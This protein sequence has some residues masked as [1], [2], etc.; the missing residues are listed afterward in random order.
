M[1]QFIFGRPST[2]KT[3]TVIEKIKEA[4]TEK[5][6]AVLIVPEQF[7]FE[8]EKA[9]LKEIGDSAALNVS[10]LSFSRLYDEVGRFSGL[11]AGTVLSDS[12]KIIMMKRAL[13][14]SKPFLSSNRYVGSSGYAKA[15]LDTVGELKINA[16]TPSDLR[17]A[18]FSISSEAL[19]Q[20][21]NDTATIYE[22]YD[23][24]VGE[25]FLDPADRL[26]KLYDMLG[27][28]EY[29]K[30]KTVLFDTFKGF[31]G[32]QYKIIDRVLSQA[33][34][35]YI[36]FTNDPDSK[37]DFNVFSNIRKTVARIERLA[38]NHS[39]KINKP[40][41]LKTKHY[42]SKSLDVLEQVVSGDNAVFA[43]RDGGVT[44]CCAENR[45]DEADFAASTIR[46]LVRDKG[47]RYRDFIIISR[48]AADYEQAVEYACIE[49]DVSCFIDKRMPLSSF[50]AAVAAQNAVKA[51]LSFST[52]S[53]L[54]FNKTGL[55]AL[56][57]EEISI[58]EN[59]VFL[60]KI[61]GEMWN[62][63]W[64]MDVRGFVTEPPEEKHL[65][66]LDE[67]NA[68]REKAIRPILSFKDSFKGTPQNLASAIIKLFEECNVSEKLKQMCVKL[69]SS[70]DEISPDILK[71]SYDMYINLLESTVRCLPET[72]V[73]KEDFVAS[74]ETAVSLS[75][76][77]VI[78]QTLDEVT[79]GSADRIRPSRPKIAFILGAN[80]GV[81]PRVNNKSGVFTS[82]ERRVLSEYGV[83]IGNDLIADAVD[84][85]FLVYTNL[86]CPSDKLYI[87]YSKTALNGEQYEKSAFLNR[88]SELIECEK[89]TY[90]ESS[91]C[92]ANL[93][94]TA[95]AAYT[96][97]CRSIN[98]SLEAAQTIKKALE[99]CGLEE[100]AQGLEN[101]VKRE[102]SISEETAQMLYGEDLYMSA[103]RIDTFSRCPFSYFC[104]YGLKAEKLR[105]AEFNVLQRGTIVHYV[106]ERLINNNAGALKTLSKTE[107][108]ELVDT[109]IEEYLDS[110][111]GYRSIETVYSRFIASKISKLLK[112][113]VSHM[114]EEFSQSCFEPYGCEVKIG[115]EGEIPALKIPFDKGNIVISG[116][117]DRLDKYNGYIR[118]VDYKTG[119]REFKISDVLYG[120]NLQ[121]LIYLYAAVKGSKEDEKAAGIL[122]MQPSREEK[123]KNTAMNGL[124]IKDLSVVTAME[125]ENRGEFVPRLSV[126]KD[127]SFSKTNNSFIDGEDFNEIFTYIDKKLCGIGNKIASGNIDIDPVDGYKSP[128]CKYCDFASVCGKEDITPKAAAVLKTD[129]AVKIIK[130]ENQNGI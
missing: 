89:V 42:N 107:S 68:L 79:F 25:S 40:V 74:L 126:N 46:K 55:G 76:V 15:V 43:E 26:S 84:E 103:S 11:T 72:E 83:E 112:E 111:K 125:A 59:Y 45:F 29:F 52:E 101:A 115:A 96:L 5:E 114:I 69:G 41:I 73:K 78:P 95:D 117:I 90:P 23:L 93:P 7:S 17:S 21:L 85:E 14:A 106:L 53:I 2:G 34:N 70:T 129:E 116:S 118:V 47:Y 127:G 8:S 87:C 48:D 82:Y 108:D 10:V 30:G 97:L 24:L 44:V 124:L 38:Q 61:E 62:K 119:S 9:I 81:F 20:K 130:E 66:Q 27:I 13:S 49:N 123:G 94:E 86:C 51:A 88:I 31:T 18:A 58:L 6:Q 57:N 33:D 12:D 91:L 104:R 28:Y 100:K 110:V 102:L 56:S 71:Q 60:W 4:V 64:D 39:V 36:S 80:Q 67:I 120:L 98:S 109:Y 54:M 16:I 75:S 122:Y 35:V 92:E 99:E 63:K 3:H 50:C 128:A 32:Q 77:G 37:K 113:V 22:N 19:S 65:K 1:L 121:M 105:P